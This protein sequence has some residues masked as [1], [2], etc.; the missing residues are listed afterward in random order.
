MTDLGAN[1]RAARDAA[2]VSLSAMAARTHYSKPLLGLLET[3]KRAIKAEHVSA[4]ARALNISVET[5]YG[6]RDDPL[7]VAHEW[8]V[9]DNPVEVHSA[10]GR[11]VGA[12]L[13][14]ELEH[15]VI[16]LRHLDDVVGGRDLLPVV[17][18][19]LVAAQRVVNDASYTEG[20]GRRLLT[21]VAELAQLT[22]WVAG[23]AGHYAEAQRVYLSGVSAARD[24]GNPALAGQLLSSLSYQIANVGDPADAV[25]LARSAVKGAEGRTTPVVRA[26]LLERIAWASARARDREGTQ[27][28]LDAVDDAYARRSEG[29]E[30]PE[31][32]YWLDRK[33]IDVMA[34]R[35]LIESGDPL[36]AE[37]LLSGAIAAYT[38]EHAREVA[39]YETWLAESYARAGMFDAARDTVDRARKTSQGV[40][41]TRLDLRIASVESL[42][43]G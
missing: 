1:L 11:R 2:G 3:G 5:L 41:S 22:G 28:A 13:A 34:G 31:W 7:R 43:P 18:Q 9:A 20:T 35:C 23:D 38:P 12:G 40:N 42:L 33:E 15:R 24:A 21:V 30:E 37:P 32:V 39:L 8:L 16:E 19:E 14:G 10:A 27:R 17:H 6:P 4:Y 29:I 26:L 25:L 36:A